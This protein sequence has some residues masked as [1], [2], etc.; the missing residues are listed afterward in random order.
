MMMMVMMMMMMMMI[1]IERRVVD[2][3]GGGCV[4]R[5]WG[6][7]IMNVMD[8]VGRAT[9]VTYARCVGI[10]HLVQL[11]KVFSHGLP[12]CSVRGGMPTV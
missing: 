1:V 9:Q 3:G 10:E 11:H 7:R 6:V 4:M 5:E 12:V 2:G 8:Q